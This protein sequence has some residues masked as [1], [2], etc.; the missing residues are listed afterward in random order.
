MVAPQ[1]SCMYKYPP[2]FI[3]INAPRDRVPRQSR[4][5][6]DEE[7]GAGPHADFFHLG[8]LDDE[9]ARHGDK[10]PG[11]EAVEGG[12]G[13]DGGVGAGGDPEG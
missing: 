8:D 7:T 9:G 11:C 5:G 1:K 10:G 12:E 3:S 6:Y 13:D 4:G 2:L